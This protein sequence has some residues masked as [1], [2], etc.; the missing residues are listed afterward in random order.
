[1]YH[2]L[3]GTRLDY[4]GLIFGRRKVNLLRIGVKDVEILTTV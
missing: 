3:N 4:K 2:F 1:M